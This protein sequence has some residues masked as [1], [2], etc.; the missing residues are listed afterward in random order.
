V[1]DVIPFDIGLGWKAMSD[2]S[3]IRPWMRFEHDGAFGGRYIK[4][5]WRSGIDWNRTPPPSAAL[6]ALFNEAIRSNNHIVPATHEIMAQLTALQT[7]DIVRL[8]GQLI[9]LER[10]G[11]ETFPLW[12]SSLSRTDTSTKWAGDNT[13]CETIYVTS[14]ENMSRH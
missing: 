6:A 10:P 3:L 9:Q 14:V 13:N 5:N 8:K 1:G 11:D 4:Y 2:L 12:K 7:G